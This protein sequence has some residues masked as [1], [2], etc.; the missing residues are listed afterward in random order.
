MMDMKDL[1]LHN[2]FQFTNLIIK[3]PA[4]SKPILKL[5]KAIVDQIDKIY[6]P[7]EEVNQEGST[8][9]NAAT[10]FFE[11]RAILEPAVEHSTNNLGFTIRL[12]DE[13]AEKIPLETIEERLEDLLESFRWWH[14]NLELGLLQAGIQPKPNAHQLF[15]K[16]F[17]SILYGKQNSLPVFGFIDLSDG[18]MISQGPPGFGMIQRFVIHR[19]ATDPSVKIILEEG[20]S[21]SEVPASS[22]TDEMAVLS[23]WYH[24]YFV[25]F[26]RDH[27]Q[28]KTELIQFFKNGLASRNGLP[29][30]ARL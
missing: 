15:L 22:A 13:R 20:E 7:V 21:A 27:L 18:R 4:P 9:S 17:K 16:W 2:P 11:M 29:S 14:E 25:H 28:N 8:P 24:L 12:T 23:H 6:G 26:W 19:L 30:I 5:E 1:P 3:T 10:R